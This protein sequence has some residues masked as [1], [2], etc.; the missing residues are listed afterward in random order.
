EHAC[1][2]APPRT[3]CETVRLELGVEGIPNH[4]SR[5]LWCERNTFANLSLVILVT[6]SPPKRR[7]IESMATVEIWLPRR[8]G[9]VPKFRNPAV[10]NDFARIKS[11]FPLR[12]T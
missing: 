2:R 11:I 9:L 7:S 6:G 10:N 8:P 3:G 12:S 1:L 5:R 4:S